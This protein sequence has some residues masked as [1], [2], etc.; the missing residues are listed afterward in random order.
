MRS[1][2]RS[3]IPGVLAML[4]GL[5]AVGCATVPAAKGPV[6]QE[7]LGEAD[8]LAIIRS[9]FEEKGYTVDHGPSLKLRNGV[10]LPADLKTSGYDM[11]VE[12]LTGSDAKTKGQVPDKAARSR[13]HVI[14][15]APADA[16]NRKERVYILVCKDSSYLYQPNPMPGNRAP[17]TL[18]EVQIR[19]KR[20][21]FDFI[22]WYETYTGQK[23]GGT[24][25]DAK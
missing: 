23:P 6:E 21:V 1:M 10:M 13:L 24:A 7:P 4:C 18:P 12:F 14:T 20:D 15:G 17:V 22:A 11:A 16:T 2:H 19:L 5:G 9:A 25:P 3:S 8:A